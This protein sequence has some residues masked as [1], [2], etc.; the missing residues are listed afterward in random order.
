MNLL[1]R[2]EDNWHELASWFCILFGNFL[3]AVTI[4]ILVTPMGMYN[5]GL[6]GLAQLIRYMI[7]ATFGNIYPGGDLAGA[8]YFCMNIPLFFYAFRSTGKAFALK[9]LV[10]ISASSVA[11]MF[12]PIPTEP[13]FPDY[14]TCCVV[15]GCL[16]GVGMGFILRGGAS[17]GGTDIVAIGLSKTHPNIS[18][19]GINNAVN[20]LVYGL[21]LVLF[22]VQIAVY[23]F[24]YAAIRSIFM[25]KL[26]AQNIKTQVVIITKEEGIGELLTKGLR[27]GVT[28]W[29]G[30]GVYTGDRVHI[31]MTLVSKYEIGRLKSITLE[32]DP[33]AFITI[34]EGE[35]IVGNFKRHMEVGK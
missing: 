17:T 35:H 20:I 21:C 4:N 34:A 32:A 33:H 27:R 13:L 5:G 31:V 2:I 25:D 26:H 11:M 8:I 30:K 19:G 12:I 1:D 10:S 15:A 9:T 6:L 18:V 28:Q 29:E 7:D 16:G 22:N 24:I 3:Y 23:S 14:L